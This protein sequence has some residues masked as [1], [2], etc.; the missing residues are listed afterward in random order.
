MFFLS[1]TF[2]HGPRSIYL[3]IMSISAYLFTISASWGCYFV[4]VNATFSAKSNSGGQIFDDYSAGF[5][6]YSYEDGAENSDNKFNWLCYTYSDEQKD[7][8]DSKFKTA[9]SFATMANIFVGIAM[10]FLIFTCCVQFTLPMMKILGVLMLIGSF[11]QVFTFLVFSSDLCSEFECTFYLGAGMSIAAVLV[12]L[13]SGILAFFV[14]GSVEPFTSEQGGPAREPFQ[15]GTVTE[16]ETIMPDGSTKITRT[17]VNFDNSK[18]IEET[19]YDPPGGND[20][21]YDET[22]AVHT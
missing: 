17:T 10:V 21:Y 15:P 11:C 4:D 20:Q 6:L 9:V 8:L 2:P 5:G 3:F 18:T 16:T 19:V 14:P 12:A 13:A 1:S 7:R 22:A